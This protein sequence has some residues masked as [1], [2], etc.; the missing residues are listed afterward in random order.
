M[1][2]WC[3]GFRNV[4]NQAQQMLTKQVEMQYVL[5]G[6]AKDSD[7]IMPATMQLNIQQ[8]W[9]RIQ[10]VIPDTK[11]NY[12]FWKV[13]KPRRST[14]SSCRAVIAAR[15][16][17]EQFEKK[18]IYAIQQAYY[19]NAKNP[20]NDEVLIQLAKEIGLDTKRFI[21]ELNSDKCNFLLNKD[22]QLVTNLQVSGFPSLVLQ[23]NNS[24][25]RIAVDY[26]DKGVIV[27]SVLE[28]I[29]SN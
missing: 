10:Q 17:G 13:C 6:L 22:F 14:Y 28:I 15:L 19:L 3:Y 27:S 20:S 12:D 21:T 24:F 9:Q 7:E 1:C 2:S 11:F 29:E 16:Q 18:M 26:N 5:G 8:N 23:I 25:F 4:W